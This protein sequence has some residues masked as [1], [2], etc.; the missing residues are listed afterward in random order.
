MTEL[1]LAVA[2]KLE[3]EERGRD[4]GQE[5]EKKSEAED[6]GDEP[7]VIDL[8]LDEGREHREGENSW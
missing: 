2:E 8:T 7:F 1:G 6:L 5:E 4:G 3:S